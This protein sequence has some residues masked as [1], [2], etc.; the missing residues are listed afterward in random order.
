MP[1]STSKRAAPHAR[2][3][4]HVPFHARN[5]AEAPEAPGV[6]LLYRGHRLVYIGLAAACATIRQCLQRHLRGEGGPCT[7]RATEFDYE[8]SAY[9]SWRYRHY[10]AVYLDATGGLLPDCNERH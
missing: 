7:H 3:G 1:T 6:Y 5:V 9:A 10:I 8:T 4:E 2:I